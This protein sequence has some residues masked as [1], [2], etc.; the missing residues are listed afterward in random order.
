MLYI[1]ISNFSSEIPQHKMFHVQL[2]SLSPPL[3]NI[4]IC[5]AHIQDRGGQT[6]QLST[7]TESDLPLPHPL[8]DLQQHW[9]L[10]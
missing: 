5:I 3:S 9:R 2:V 7:E 10:V 4:G 6:Y 1:S 8:P